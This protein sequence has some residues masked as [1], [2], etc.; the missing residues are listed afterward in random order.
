VSFQAGEEERLLASLDLSAEELR[1]QPALTDGELPATIAGAEGEAQHI[2]GTR[3]RDY[4]FVNPQGEKVG[5]V[6]DLMLDLQQHRVIYLALASGGLLGSGVKLL[7]VPM[8]AITEWNRDEQRVVVDFS[9]EQVE[10]A[11]GFDAQEWPNEATQWWQ[12]APAEAPAEEADT[13]GQQTY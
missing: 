6:D 5:S 4:T 11:E 9:K 8:G 1:D 7:T 12:A 2:L 13:T 10:Q 3:L